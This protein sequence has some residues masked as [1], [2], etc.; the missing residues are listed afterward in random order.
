MKFENPQNS[1]CRTSD[2]SAYIDGEL[3]PDA[4]IAFEI[5]GVQ[6]AGDGGPGDEQGGD[7]RER[8]QFHGIPRGDAPGGR[9]SI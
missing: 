6:S 2:I 8:Q 3:S 4:E 9:V 5:A 7:E 1:V